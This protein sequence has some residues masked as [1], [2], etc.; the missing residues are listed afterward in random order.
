M[1]KIS[2]FITITFYEILDNLEYYKTEGKDN[3]IIF[4]NF[5]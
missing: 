1:N 4:K 5:N 3:F 2:F